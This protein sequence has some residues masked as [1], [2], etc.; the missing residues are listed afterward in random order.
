MTLKA[1]MGET[2]TFEPAVL[3]VGLLYPAADPGA[4]EDA[5]ARLASRW[6][7]DGFRSP[8]IPFTLSPYYDQELGTPILRS[9]RCFREPVDPSLL[10]EAKLFT[11][12]VESDLSRDGRRRVNLDPGLLF[13]SRLILATTKDRAHRIPLRDG[14]FAELTLL[15]EHGAWKSLPWTYPDYRTPEYAEALTRMRQI[16]RAWRKRG[17]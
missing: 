17:A 5:W 3:F 15:Y 2:A 4:A 7:P 11:N 9:L 1:S 8:E 14:I 12:Q 10:P 6:G 13:P 16:H